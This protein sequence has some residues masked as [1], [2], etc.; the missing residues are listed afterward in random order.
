MSDWLCKYEGSV[1]GRVLTLNTEGPS[2]A[3]PRK[4]AKMKDV[5]EVKSKDHKVLTSYIQGE[6]GKWVLFMTLNAK[7]KK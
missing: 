2:P 7:R 3:D 4:T 1:D 5:I 6:D